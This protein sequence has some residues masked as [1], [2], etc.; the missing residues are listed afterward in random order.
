MQAKKN[1]AALRLRL[2]LHRGAEKMFSDAFVDSPKI[3]SFHYVLRYFLIGQQEVFMQNVPVHL[4][5]NF[6]LLR[7]S[8]LL[9]RIPKGLD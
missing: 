7:E 1:L 2:L 9:Q 5:L 8:M 3:V 6:S 4:A